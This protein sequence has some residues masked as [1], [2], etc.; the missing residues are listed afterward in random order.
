MLKSNRN[1]A[2]NSY[3]HLTAKERDSLSFPAKHLLN[4]GLIKG[5]VLDFGCGYG[6]DVELLKVKGLE[7]EGYDKYY[8]KDYPEGKFDT[9]LCF[10]VLNVLQAQAQA[11]VLMEISELLKPGGSAYIAV[12]R[13]IVHEGYRMHKV[14]QKPTY[15]CQVRLNY[16]TVFRNDNCEIYEYKHYNF[17]ES[18]VENTTCPFC[19]LSAEAEII[20]ESATV[21]SI[22][23]KYPV[24]PGH[25][26]IIPK[27]HIA[28]YFDLTTW[29]QSALWFMANR[30][31]QL[32][33][34]HHHPD[35]FNIGINAGTSAGQT[36][37]HIHI[38][39]IPR[40]QH[41][42]PNPEGGVRAVIPGKAK[43]S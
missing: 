40:Y 28:N 26:L 35:G 41:D 20:T 11:Q 25:A 7:V 32:L 1:M 22:Y 42:V 34:R 27:K 10:Y 43:Y 5:R 38:H 9:I 37:N 6:S 13:D 4:K 12:R 31:Q 39:L 30:V 24:S 16:S 14:H 33:S 36:I 29:E 23:D 19:N 3:N 21:Y 15:Q 17:A 2:T 18:L 8:F